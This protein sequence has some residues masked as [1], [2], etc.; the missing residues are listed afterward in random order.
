MF[1]APIA[2]STDPSSSHEA[3]AFVTAVGARAAQQRLAAQAVAAYPGCTALELSAKSG[4]CRY[5]LNRRLPECETHGAVVRGHIRR[6]NASKSGRSAV[7]WWPPGHVEQLTLP[8]A[9]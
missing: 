5:V 9:A 6:C 2:R 1:D 7:T 8:M 4:I 3:A